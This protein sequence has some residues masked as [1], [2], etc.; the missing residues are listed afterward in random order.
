[1][2]TTPIASDR[3]RGPLKVQSGR[4]D[5]ERRKPASSL[6]IHESVPRLTAGVWPENQVM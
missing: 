5:V 4:Q 3:V 6:N 1:M 2:A